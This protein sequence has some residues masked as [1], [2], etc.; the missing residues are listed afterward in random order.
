MNIETLIQ[1]VRDN[2]Q[3][4][5]V[6]VLV[7]A[8]I[9]AAAKIAEKTILKDTV[10]RISRTKYITVCGMLGALAAILHIFDFPLL[11]LAPEFYKLDFG[12]L[13]AMIGGFFLGPVGAVIIE[14]A[15][16]LLKLVI[17]GTSTAFVGDFANFVIGCTLLV[18]ASIVYHLKKTKTNAAAGL[19]A[20]TVVMAVFGTAFNAIYLLPAF[21][22]L[23]GMPLDAIIG[24][25]TAINGN[26]NSVFTFV[27]F[28]V[29]PLNLIKGALVSVLT[30][31]LYKRISLFLHNLAA[32][33][34]SRRTVR[35]AQRP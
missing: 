28:T 14:L 21:S 4:L 25:G 2:L 11:F 6:C 26:V 22:A 27:V 33:G 8:A 18:P 5:L 15:K 17:K 9:V 29:F 24:M 12:E 34:M 19:A 23:Y 32:D 13:P 3:F 30:M 20:G 35:R 31:L 16:I 1:Q 10:I 7:V